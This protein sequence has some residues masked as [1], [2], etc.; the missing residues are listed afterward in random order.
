MKR[1]PQQTLC[2]GEITAGQGIAHLGAADSHTFKLNGLRRFDG[3]ALHRACLLQEFKIA[4]P[5]ATKTEIVAD[6]QMLNA[7]AIDQNSVYELGGTELAQALIERQAQHPVDT[8]VSQQLQLVAQPGQTCRRRVRGKELA[9]LRLENHHAAGHA[10]L[11]RTLT[12]PA[13]D[14]LVT[15]VYT[16]K[17]ANSG[18]T[19]PMLGPQ[20]VKA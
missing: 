12:Q 2:Q 14:C 11:Q 19:A 9:R 13:Q 20:I 15:T 3:K 4:H 17:V 10:Q 16:V 7:Q 6:L 8:G 1:A 18:D 5:V